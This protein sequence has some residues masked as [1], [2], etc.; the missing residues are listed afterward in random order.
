[1]LTE[2]GNVYVIKIVE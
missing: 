2:K 1:V